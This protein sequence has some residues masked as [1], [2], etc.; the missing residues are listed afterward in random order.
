MTLDEAIN[1]W[2][3]RKFMVQAQCDTCWDESAEMALNALK[4]K[5]LTI[6]ISWIKDWFN[7][8]EKYYGYE[9]LEII[10]T[11]LEDWRHEQNE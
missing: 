8:M 1:E 2:E 5:K 9:D 3:T 7:Y 11:M 10:L 6:P 4:E